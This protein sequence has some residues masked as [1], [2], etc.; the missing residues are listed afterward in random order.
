VRFAAATE[1]LTACGTLADQQPSATLVKPVRGP[2]RPSRPPT[3]AS[4]SWAPSCLRWRLYE[5]QLDRLITT[6]AAVPSDAIVYATPIGCGNSS[7]SIV[8]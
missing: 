4:R 5:A 7:A 3:G 1:R 2:R 6:I 8:P